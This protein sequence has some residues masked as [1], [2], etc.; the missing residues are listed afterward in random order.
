MKPMA[1]IGLL[2]GVIAAQEVID[3][4]HTADL[5]RTVTSQ[6]K[7]YDVVINAQRTKSYYP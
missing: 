6:S 5:Q 1:G 7:S 4:S 3:F 2:I